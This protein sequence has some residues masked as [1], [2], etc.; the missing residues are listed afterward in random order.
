MTKDQHWERVAAIDEV[1]G[2]RP[3]GAAIRG[4]DLVLVPSSA[5]IRAF[6]GVCPHR[7]TLLSE[8]AVVGSEIVCRAHGWRFDCETGQRRGAVDQPSLVGLPCRTRDDFVEVSPSQAA[9]NG[10]Q[11]QR[12]LDDLPGPR[13][14]PVIGN[15]F[16]LRP[17]AF[18]QTL[19]SWAARYGSLYR[20]AL[21]GRNVMIVSDAKIIERILRQR[22]GSF[23]RVPMIEFITRELGASGVFS[24][25]GETWRRERRLAMAALAGPNLRAFYPTLV[26]MAERLKKRWA[27]AAADGRT[28]SI[29]SD[30]RRFTVDVTTNLA[31]G[32]DMNTL[33]KE[34]VVQEQ[35]SSILAAVHRRLFAP[36]PYWHWVKLP[37][38]RRTEEARAAIGRMLRALMAGARTK[39]AQI[40][41]A[42]RVPQNFLEAML[43]ARDDEGHA[44][45]D[46]TIVGNLL[47]LLITGDDTT[48]N[49]LAWIVHETL[50][51]PAVRSRLAEEA[52]RVL[53]GSS[54]PPD[55]ETTSRL[56]YADAVANETMR[57]RQ[58]VPLLSLQAN[59]D[60][61]IDGVLLPQGGG[62]FPLFRPP[63]LD[64]KH[65][66]DARTFR[67][68]RW[69]DPPSG[70]HVPE[71]H[72]PFGSG[73]RF[74]PGRGLALL[75]IRVV[76]AMLMKSFEI[77]RVGDP[78]A[79]KEV[80]SMHLKPDPL[81]VRFRARRA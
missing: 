14:W 35:L 26:R 61:V 2:D 38:D 54:I 76:L 69:I 57:F 27:M 16:E 1:S 40:P 47:T 41:E 71:S 46:E 79:V 50:E 6:E 18:L 17:A 12:T 3:T 55:L 4:R 19:E 28:V 8:G 15:M 21:G 66:V 53:G 56:H 24:S 75:E 43:L 32:N 78:G 51:R 29:L 10:L 64:D 23:R 44:F 73:P 20:V 48:S 81:T 42:E 22:P 74:C 68:E 13:R 80:Y 70:A 9:E 7:G 31:F 5:G 49:V 62:V 59:E 11:A 45:S 33:E 25:E 58:I 37:A 63:A 67:P 39:L 65:F 72:M 60:V 34:E 52:D 77:E 36:F 30:F